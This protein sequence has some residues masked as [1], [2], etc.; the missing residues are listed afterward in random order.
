MDAQQ[1]FVSG[2][3]DNKTI[4]K[5]MRTHVADQKKA[6]IKAAKDLVKAEAKAAKDLV[7]ANE[8]AVK[9]QA[10]AATAAT[11]G[12]K[13]KAKK[14]Q[15]K[16]E[17]ADL[18]TSLVTLANS[19]D[20]EP[21][22]TGAVPAEEEEELDVQVFTHDGKSYLID[23]NNTLYDNDTHTVIGTWDKDNESIVLNT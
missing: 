5:E 11:K 12:T 23:D 14:L 1:L 3:L 19:T 6:V 9:A 8:K 4:A 16:P 20:N 22:N 2:F 17:E 21:E 10:K 13:T 18:V 7:K 15:K